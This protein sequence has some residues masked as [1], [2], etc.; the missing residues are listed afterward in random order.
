MP[1]ETYLQRLPFHNR[2]MQLEII[3]NETGLE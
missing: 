3:A 1:L 2:L